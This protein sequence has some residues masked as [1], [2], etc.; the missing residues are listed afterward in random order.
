MPHRRAVCR[1]ARFP[2]SPKRRSSTTS[3]RSTTTS[4]WSIWRSPL[5]GPSSPAPRSPSPGN[6][7]GIAAAVD[8][9]VAAELA[10]ANRR[11]LSCSPECKRGRT[12]STRRRSPRSL[13]NGGRYS[14]GDGWPVI[15]PARSCPSTTKIVKGYVS[16]FDGDQPEGTGRQPQ[17]L[18]RRR[19]RHRRRV[20]DRKTRAAT[21][22]SPYRDIEAH[23]FNPEDGDQG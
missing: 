22:I 21:P 23:D 4:R 8:K 16:L 5:R 1:L 15:T 18:A 20:V 10:A 13:A 17:V 2:G 19:R 7:P 14:D 9:L 3:R 12:G 11:R 6:D